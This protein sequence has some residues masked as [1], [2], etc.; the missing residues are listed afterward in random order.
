MASLTDRPKMMRSQIAIIPRPD[1]RKPSGR[2]NN[3]PAYYLLH[4]ASN[5]FSS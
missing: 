5:G 4:C 1:V 3:C 2:Q